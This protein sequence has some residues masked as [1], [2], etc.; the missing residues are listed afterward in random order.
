M[1]FDAFNLSNFSVY[2]TSGARPQFLDDQRSACLMPIVENPACRAPQSPAHLYGSLSKPYAT[3]WR[4]CQSIRLR[5]QLLNLPRNSQKSTS[6]GSRSGRLPMP[7]C[8]MPPFMPTTCTPGFAGETHHPR[9]EA[10][11]G[12]RLGG[13]VDRRSAS[14]M[15]YWRQGRSEMSWPPDPVRGL[16]TSSLLTCKSRE[17]SHK[18][19]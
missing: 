11:A 14:F 18:L 12:Q 1:Y 17:R 2:T 19:L 9:A 3:F 6:T 15:K 5:P 16:P 8:P 7:L 4:T 10:H 13:G